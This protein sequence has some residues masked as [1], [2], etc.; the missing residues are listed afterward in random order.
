LPPKRRRVDE[1]DASKQT[2]KA[3]RDT[4]Y[5]DILRVLKQAPLWQA[6]Q[7]RL[8]P[9][10]I[11]E[12]VTRQHMT[13]FLRPP[14]MCERLCIRRA[15]CLGCTLAVAHRGQ[16]YTLGQF[17][18]PSGRVIAGLCIMCLRQG[19]ALQNNDAL[20]AYSICDYALVNEVWQLS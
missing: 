5:K 16:G 17:V 3:L 14:A 6:D 10:V 2:L 9:I 11:S 8:P 12:T 13:E 7:P 4:L 20:G 18:F 1:A 15:S 19:L